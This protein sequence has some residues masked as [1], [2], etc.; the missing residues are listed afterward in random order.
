MVMYKDN[1]SLGETVVCLA[2]DHVVEGKKDWNQNKREK[3]MGGKNCFENWFCKLKVILG[4]LWEEKDWP[5]LAF[6]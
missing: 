2:E 1:P 5:Y 4:C 6:I 3:N